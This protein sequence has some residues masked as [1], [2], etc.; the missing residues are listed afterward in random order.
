M[1]DEQPPPTDRHWW[2]AVATDI[3]FWVSVAFVLLVPTAI[4]LITSNTT[5]AGI[6]LVCGCF[7][8]LMSKFESLA[9]LTIGPLKAKMRE[10]AEDNL[11]AQLNTARGALAALQ[12]AEKL[13]PSPSTSDVISATTSTAVEAVTA[14]IRANDAITFATSSPVSWRRF[15]LSPGGSAYIISKP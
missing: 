1:S 10:V 9:E 8:A 15:E 7:V 2:T 14:A 3:L 13:P 12:A 5:T 6:A 4:G 11:R